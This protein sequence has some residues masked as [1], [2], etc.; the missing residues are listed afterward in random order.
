MASIEL[1]CLQEI[2][3][4]YVFKIFSGPVEVW[5]GLLLG[6]GD[7]CVAWNGSCDKSLSCILRGEFAEPFFIFESVVAKR[8]KN[9]LN[10]LI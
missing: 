4:D 2:E 7:R 10:Q 8:E 6:I 9:C 5:Q 1:C 3:I